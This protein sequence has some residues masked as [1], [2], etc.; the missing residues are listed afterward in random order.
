MNSFERSA[1]TALASILAVRMMGLFMI[2]PVFS[3]YAH[4]LPGATPTLVGLALGIYGLTQTICQIPFG[5]LSDRFGRKP[6]IVVGLLIFAAGSVIAALATSITGIIIGRALQGGSAIAAAVLA[7]ASDLTR[8]EQRTKAMAILGMSIGLSFIVALVIGP[9][10]SR[11]LGMSG[12]FWLTSVL[13]LV[14]IVLLHLIVPPQPKR[15]SQR[16]S[17]NR[18]AITQFKHLLTDPQLFRL[19]FSTL[20]LHLMLT[21]LF[22]G[23][24]LALAHQLQATQHWQIYLPVLTAAFFATVPFIIFAEKHHQLKLMLVSSVGVIG[25][26]ELGFIYLNQHF[27]GVALMLFLFFTAVNL[28]EANLPSL[29]SKMAPTDSK[30][31]AMGMYSTAQFF[32]AFLGGISGGWLLHHYGIEAIF[33]FCAILSGGWFIMVA[34]MPQPRY[35]SSELLPLGKIDQ[36]H[37]DQ[38]TECLTQVPGVAEVVVILEE[39]MAYLKVDRNTLDTTALKKCPI[40]SALSRF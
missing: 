7:L 12:I 38:L 19:N 30:G 40:I 3:L 10:L 4:Q 28:L 9:I 1:I 14:A 15:Y 11:W 22:V 27:T 6:I 16:P 23:L 2:L 20:L 32:G 8:E 17:S 29:I 39:E 24:P 31:T 25:L 21:S 34:T 26:A 35:L 18:T 36:Q 5:M 13:A 37:L 33:I